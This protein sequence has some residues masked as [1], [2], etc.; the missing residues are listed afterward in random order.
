MGISVCSG[1]VK[2]NTAR[3]FPTS[4]VVGNQAQRR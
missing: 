1:A 2:L 3:L 4:T